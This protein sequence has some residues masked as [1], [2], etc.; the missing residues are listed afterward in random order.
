M[1]YKTSI[2]MVFS[3]LRIPANVWTL[4]ILIPGLLS[5]YFIIE[6]EFIFAGAF[7]LV[8]MVVDVIDGA[9]AHVTTK[10]TGKGSFLDVIVTSYIEAFILFGLAL[11]SLPNLVIPASVWAMTALFGFLGME[12]SSLL[13]KQKGLIEK[14]W[15]HL[16][17]KPTRLGLL[18]IIVFSA[19]YDTVFAVS[20]LS[21]VAGISVI[22][23]LNRQV[24]A[25][26]P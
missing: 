15:L 8:A 21:V 25:L 24:K 11:A 10:V 9:V 4:L 2:G 1:S 18:A 13:A 12:Y 19:A 20:L 23:M 14:D 26:Y 6:K 3:K 5:F 17:V 7:F 16:V 22:A